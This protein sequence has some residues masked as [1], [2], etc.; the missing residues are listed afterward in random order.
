MLTIGR[1]LAENFIRNRNNPN[2]SAIA[3]KYNSI[4]WRC[5]F[6]ERRVPMSNYNNLT[7]SRVLHCLYT[8]LEMLFNNFAVGNPCEAH[9][10]FLAHGLTQSRFRI[11]LIRIIKWMANLSA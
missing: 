10:S 4:I 8:R 3:A 9:G 2:C 11:A 7:G 5:A 6:I 1:A